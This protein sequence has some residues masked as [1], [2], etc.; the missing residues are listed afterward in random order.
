MFKRKK[1]KRK[2]EIWQISLLLGYHKQHG[3][4]YFTK[5][6][7]ML[8]KAQPAQ[9]LARGL[10]RSITLSSHGVGHWHRSLRQRVVT[11]PRL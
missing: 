5:D 9:R 6:A 11:W 3:I 1:Q 2:E 8:A 7:L 10:L 4:I